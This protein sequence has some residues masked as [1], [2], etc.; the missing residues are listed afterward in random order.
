MLHWFLCQEYANERHAYTE[1]KP[2]SIRNK[3]KK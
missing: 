2:S 3:D 1:F